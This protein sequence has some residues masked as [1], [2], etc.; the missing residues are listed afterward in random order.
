MPIVD[1]RFDA[2]Y[3]QILP[4]MGDE[5]APTWG[6]DDVL[7]TANDDGNSFGGVPYNAIAFGKL[8][9]DDPYALSGM[10]VNGMQDYYEIA[11]PGP[12]GAAWNAVESYRL[13]EVVYRFDTCK[14]P[15]FP[16]TRF[17]APRLIS[18]N[19][20]TE[21]LLG[22]K[23]GEFIY[24]AAYAGGTGEEDTYV[25]GRV[26]REKFRG[27][28]ISDWMF[29]QSDSSWTSDL[30]KALAIPNSRRLG[31]DGANWKTMNCY[32]VEGALYMFVTRCAYPSGS[33]DP[34][35]RHIFQNSSI[36]KS[37]DNGRTWTRSA[38]ENY[39]KPMFSGQRFGAPYFVWY[40]KDGAAAVDNA[41][42]YVYAVSNN[43]HFENGDDY[44]LGRVL[45]SRLSRLAADD[46]SFYE[47]GDGMCGDSWTSSLDQAKPILTNP[48][49][50]SMTG[51]TY[52]EQLNRYVMVVWHYHGANFERAIKNKDLGTVL[53]FFEAGKP[54]GPWTLV[55]SFDTGRLGWYAPIIGQRF[56][57]VVDAH[58]VRSFMYV[59]GLRTMPQG[60]LDFDLYKLNYI[61]VTLSTVPLRHSVPGFVGDSAVQVG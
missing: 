52:I 12:E 29:V 40:G 55:K 23:P 5:W 27:G 42:T 10:T 54:W 47:G 7:Y 57:S 39:S 17:S 25:V 38:D 46:W 2:T 6:P 4:S 44:I 36:I 9:G 45:K 13:G 21:H 51:M 59:T 14:K 53:E 28:T 32:S 31:T 20:E 34:K 48:G 43:G 41:D 11:P 50:S 33:S 24:A 37:T 15:L 61:P 16:G 19:R 26:L 22:G 30:E 3:R 58:A 49:R 8:E 60:G 56:Q 35:R 18:Y 1:V